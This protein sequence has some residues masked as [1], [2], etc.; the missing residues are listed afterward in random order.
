MNLNVLLVLSTV[1]GGLINTQHPLIS[2]YWQ[3]NK[4][5]DEH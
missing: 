1:T 3:R 4:L 5:R 2:S